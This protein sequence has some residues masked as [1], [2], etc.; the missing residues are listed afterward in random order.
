MSLTESENE[1]LSQE[2]NALEKQL[3][4]AL[5]QL[6]EQNKDS[7]STKANSSQIELELANLKAEKEVF[8]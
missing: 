4:T 2:Y 3:K 7:E 8:I 1:R 5:K 6:K